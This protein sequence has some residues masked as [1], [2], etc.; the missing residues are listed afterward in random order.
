MRGVLGWHLGESR[1]AKERRL[2]NEQQV[3]MRGE[4]EADQELV[5]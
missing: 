2:R 5:M 1:T 3:E 4:L